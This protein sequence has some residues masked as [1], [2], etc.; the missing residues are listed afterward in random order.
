MAKNNKKRD[1]Y[2]YRDA[3]VD[4]DAAVAAV[5]R[6]KK[7]AAATFTPGVISGIGSFGALFSPD[8]S[9]VQDPVLV[10]SVDGVGTKLKIAFMTGLHNTVGY[11]LVAH[12]AND[13]LCQGA[14]PL[15]FLDYIALGKLDPRVVEDIISGIARGCREVGCALIGGETAEMPGFY[16]PGEYDLVGFIVGLV[17]R[18]LLL[19]GSKVK[20]GDLLLALPSAGLH[21]NGFSLARKLLFEV[22]GWKVDTFVPELGRTLAEELLSRHKSYLLPLKELVL[23]GKINAL[24]HI[25]GGGIP[26]NLPR[27]LP[28]GLSAEIVR[29]SWE[30]PPI[31]NLL[32]SIGNVPE[33]E[34]FRTFNMGLGM[35]LI[36][37]PE[38]ESGVKS[39]IVRS[40]EHCYNIG[41]MVAGEGGVRYVGG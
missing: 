3:G 30:V 21:T 39:H 16:A 33:E 20:E 1:S 9:R 7:L 8:F 22:K 5:S 40:G 10:S 27:V 36:V 34:M 23:S 11:D 2:T 24:A 14:V 4:I 18:S 31:F 15:F 37:S 41:V 28:P 38:K 25:T 13:I 35:I 32:S 29:R 17:D 6:I 19:T 12:S 26:G